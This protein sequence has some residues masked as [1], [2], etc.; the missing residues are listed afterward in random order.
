MIPNMIGFV[1]RLLRYKTMLR[2]FQMPLVVT[3]IHRQARASQWIWQYID[4]QRE[5]SK[6]LKIGIFT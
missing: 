2:T 4:W 1:Y 5:R 6:P 3:N